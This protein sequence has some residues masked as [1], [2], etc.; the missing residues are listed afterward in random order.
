MDPLAQASRVAGHGASTTMEYQNERL[1]LPRALASLSQRDF[2]IFWGSQILSLIGTWMQTVAQS[3]LVLQLSNSP[4]ALGT[5]T[6]LQFLP[7]L[8]FSL[9]GGI[10]ADRLPKRGVLLVTQS[11]QMA[12]AFVLAYLALTNQ[13][14]LGAI[15]II[16]ACLGLVT[17]VDMPTRQ[18]IVPE[19]VG[20]VNLANAI[21]L[22]S[23]A[24]NSA[25]LIGPAVAG[26]AI[27][28]FGI[29]ACFFLNGLCFVIPIGALLIIRA[30]RRAS[31]RGVGSSSVAKDLSEGL[32]YVRW[33][34]PVRM[35]VITVAV[36]GTFGMNISVLVPLLARNVLSAGADGYGYLTAATG[37]GALVAALT[38]AQIG[39]GVR[40]SMLIGSA[41][42][43]GVVQI[44]LAATTTF[45]LSALELGILGFAMISFTTLANMLL[46][47]EVP[48]VLRGRVMSLYTTV[49]AGTVPIGA[50]L[51]GFIAEHAGVDSAF[52]AGGVVCVLTAAFVVWRRSRV[53]LPV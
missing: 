28:G 29:A 32:A 8:L 36:I 7:I 19:L 9:F 35:V 26:L 39:H 46:Q 20:G 38:L 31:V 40:S 50:L 47:L 4:I 44:T 51:A 15:M 13:A 42:A 12:L 27:G 41:A 24:F 3:W 34:P 6:A 1:P 33:T 22:N 49:F 18:A 43:L 17:A 10:L 37:L 11:A 2:R 23:A 25:R 45:P 16:A 5:V 48:N 30:G 14:T 21:A 53:H 52:L